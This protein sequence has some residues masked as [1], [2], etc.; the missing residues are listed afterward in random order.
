[1]AR[2][3]FH[4]HAINFKYPS[5][6]S[7]FVTIVSMFEDS[8]QLSGVREMSRKSFQ[9]HTRHNSFWR[10][11][12]TATCAVCNSSTSYLARWRHCST[13]PS[14]RMRSLRFNNGGLPCFG[15]PAL[16]I[17]QKCLL[18]SSIHRRRPRVFFNRML[19]VLFCF[20]FE[21][22]SVAVIAP[23]T[24]LACVLQRFHARVSRDDLSVIGKKNKK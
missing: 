19:N 12:Q 16:T 9:T 23:R 21:C 13:F 22:M 17:P 3:C 24:G 1:M 10:Q 6:L 8:L 2:I 4:R 7:V 14:T 18:F 5:S 15:G 11:P 20:G